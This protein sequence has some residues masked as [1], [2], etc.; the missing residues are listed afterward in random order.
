MRTAL[1]SAFIAGMALDVIGFAGSI[2]SI[3]IDGQAP[4]R[5]TVGQLNRNLD[6]QEAADVR[7][8]DTGSDKYGNPR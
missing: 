4:P 6:D 7:P 3:P 5:T 2:V 8:F 1:T